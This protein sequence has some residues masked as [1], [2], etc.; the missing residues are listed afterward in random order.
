MGFYFDG[1][2]GKRGTGANIN[3]AHMNEGYFFK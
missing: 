2:Q 3:E 1:R